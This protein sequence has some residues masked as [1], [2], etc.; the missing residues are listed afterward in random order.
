MDWNIWATLLQTVRDM[1]F[2]MQDYVK[3]VSVQRELLVLVLTLNK[4]FTKW[5]FQAHNKKPFFFI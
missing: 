5:G 2:F 3:I 1:H 4:I